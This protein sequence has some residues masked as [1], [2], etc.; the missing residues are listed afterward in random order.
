M[1]KNE[2]KHVAKIATFER[3]RFLSR[4]FGPITLL[5]AA[6]LLRSGWNSGA[7]ES[8]IFAGVSSETFLAFSATRR[9]GM[10][11]MKKQID[12]MRNGIQS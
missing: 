9:A 7:T 5:H 4:V 8:E 3:S 6:F 11:I 10:N 12:A 2:P 1:R